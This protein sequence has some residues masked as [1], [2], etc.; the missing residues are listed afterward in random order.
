MKIKFR[1]ILFALLGIVLVGI[2]VY[3]A[4]VLY[5][6]IT[7]SVEAVL[8]PPTPEPVTKVDVV[9]TTHDMFL[10]ELIGSSD[11]TVVAVPAE[12]VPRD[13]ISSVEDVVNKFI[14]TDLVQGEMILKHNLADPTNI[15]HD[16]AFI[17]SDNHVLFAFPANDMMSSHSIIQRGDIVDLFTTISLE[18]GNLGPVEGATSP[19]V[20]PTP[21]PGQEEEIRPRLLTMD[22]YQV[23]EITALIADIITSE[24]EQQAIQE[25]GGAPDR[26]QIRVYGYLLALPPQDA[27][28]LKHMLDTGAKF[29]M[30][31]RAPTSRGKFDLTPV[32]KEYIVE[33]YGLG[34]VP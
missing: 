2:G 30:V 13:S 3:A 8:A 14:K 6:N 22:A 26:G 27:L 34:I 23:L 10:G 7:T 28:L 1:A 29:D 18:V 20:V 5:R 19:G 4:T 11:V 16:L 32:T 15:N 24:E 12:Y 31:L 33:L 17:L 9:V 25:S 21:Q